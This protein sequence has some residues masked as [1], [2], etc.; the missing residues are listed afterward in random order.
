MMDRVATKIY[1][2]WADNGYEF[3]SPCHVEYIAG[4]FTEEGYAQLFLYDNGFELGADGQYWKGP[5]LAWIEPHDLW[6]TYMS[7]R[8]R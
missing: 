6:D 8:D 1:L 2:V 4:I 5:L 7:G 3:D